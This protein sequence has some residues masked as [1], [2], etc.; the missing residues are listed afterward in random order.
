VKER[1]QEIEGS[2]DQVPEWVDP[3]PA[4]VSFDEWLEL[5]ERVPDELI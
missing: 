2:R 3:K 4:R 5:F 1:D